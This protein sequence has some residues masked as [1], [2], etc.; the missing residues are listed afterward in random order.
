MRWISR[1]QRGSC[2]GI[3]TEASFIS[4]VYH[5]PSPGTSPVLLLSRR[6][7]ADLLD[8]RRCIA[9][10]EQAFRLYGEG[11]ATPP[12]VT[13]VHVAGGGFH[14]KAGALAVGGRVYF[15]AK[16]NGNF[17]ANPRAHG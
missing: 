6:D 12:A 1:S 7:V 14:V 16:V 15:A 5:P 4:Q 13:A 9:A 2:D 10:V 17:P 8:L 3:S 11:K